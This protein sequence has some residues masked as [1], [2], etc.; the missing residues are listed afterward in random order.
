MKTSLLD[1]NNNFE[2][3][4]LQATILSVYLTFYLK[5]ITLFV[6]INTF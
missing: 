3:N 5:E 1:P 2:E 6:A 4:S